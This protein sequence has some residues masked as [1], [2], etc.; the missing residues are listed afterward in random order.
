MSSFYCGKN[1][2]WNM[3]KDWNGECDKSRVKIMSGAGFVRNYKL[4]SEGYNDEISRILIGPYDA[5]TLG[6]IN[7]YRNVDC[8]GPSA[9]VYWNPEDPEG[10]QY[11]KS[12]LARMGYDAAS[13]SSIQVPKGYMANLYINDGLNGEY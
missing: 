4:N 10:G 6:A 11:N 8:R 12:D 7:I 13:G 2:W 3:C 1:I 5:A 9:R